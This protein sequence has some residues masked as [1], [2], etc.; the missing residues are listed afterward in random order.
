MLKFRRPEWPAIEI[1]N[2][3]TNCRCSR[4]SALLYLILILA[5]PTLSPAVQAQAAGAQRAIEKLER[6]SK[7]ER[8]RG[9]VNILKREY[10]GDN[11]RAIKA[12]IRRSHIIWYEYNSKTGKVRRTN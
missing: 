5:L 8:Q 10:R 6:C 9:C 3:L 1:P 4:L 12:Q 2:L 11:K 7:E